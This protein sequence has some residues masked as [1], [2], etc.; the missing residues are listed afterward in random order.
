MGGRIDIQTDNVAQS[1]DETRVG[2]EFGNCF[3]VRPQAVAPQDALTEL[4]MM[5]TT[6]AIMA[7]VQWV[8]SVG[9][10]LGFFFF[11]VFLVF[12]LLFFF[13]WGG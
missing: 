7:E 8:A 10:R 2:E 1:V 9:V 12:F 11:L 3:T 5:P 4:A 13:F 6:V